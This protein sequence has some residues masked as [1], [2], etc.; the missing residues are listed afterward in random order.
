MSAASAGRG[1][2]PGLLYVD[3]VAHRPIHSRHRRIRPVPQT[4]CLIRRQRS[5]TRVSAAVAKSLVEATDGVVS[6]RDVE[7]VVWRPPVVET[8]GPNAGHAAF[9]HLF[10]FV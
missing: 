3:V 7:H 4:L 2:S 9:G 6:G 8:V 1:V 5:F 10:D